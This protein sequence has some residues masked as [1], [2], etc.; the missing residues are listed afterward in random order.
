VSRILGTADML[1]GGFTHAP[2]NPG[3]GV[4]AVILQYGG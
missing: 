2:G 3:V 1:G 4:V